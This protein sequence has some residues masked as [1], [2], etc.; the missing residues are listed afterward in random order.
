MLYYYHKDA[1]H[2]SKIDLLVKD[3]KASKA[4]YTKNLGFSI[5]EETDNHISLTV[6]H[7]NE[8][9]C[10]HKN[11]DKAK[12]IDKQ[13]GY[14]FAI[15]LPSRKDLSKF[16]HH[17][18]VNQIPID[19]AAD[20]MVSEAI[21]LQDPNGIGIEISCDR[22]DS[23][24]E[25]DEEHYKMDALPFD[26]EGVFY[27]AGETDVF[28]TLPIETTIGHVHLLSKDIDKIKSF[29]K[30]IIGFDV[31]NE[32]KK[33]AVYLA[34]KNYH[35]HVSINAIKNKVNIYRTVLSLTISYPN[36][37]KFKKAYDTIVESNMSFEQTNEGIRLN[38]PEQTKIYLKLK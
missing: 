29:Y 6:D 13:I 7:E 19:G 4:F 20:H 23:K 1:I 14:V 18:I 37:E 17:C 9:I 5:L 35:H 28:D 24:W 33:E 15:L 32:L 21:Y 12:N 31:V 38:D 30:D 11:K 36:C 22:D 2:V 10:L 26:Y 25:K 27:E 3:L 8:I 16:L 34:D